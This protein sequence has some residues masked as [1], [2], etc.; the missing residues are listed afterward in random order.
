MK[1]LQRDF[2][3]YYLSHSSQ[4]TADHFGVHRQTVYQQAKRLKLPPKNKLHSNITEG[5]S[6]RQKEIVTGCLLGDA[7]LSKVTGRIN[8][9]F[10]TIHCQNQQQWVEWKQNEL[11]PFATKIFKKQVCRTQE[12]WMQK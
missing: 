6:D 4:E 5:L 10:S 9:S 8:S 7:S 11:Q 1:T 2:V 3:D 12:R